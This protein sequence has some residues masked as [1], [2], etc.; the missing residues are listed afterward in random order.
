MNHR[1]K[2]LWMPALACITSSS[3]AMMF[4]QFA[5]IRPQLIWTKPVAFFFY[6]PWLGMLPFCGALGAW[7]SRRAGGG[8]LSR[9]LAVLSPVLWMLALGILVE[10]LELASNGLAH[11]AYFGYGIANWVV[12]PGLA[13]LIGAAPFLRERA[14]EHEAAELEA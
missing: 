5:Q 3:L 9:L 2:S 6:W 4:L 10:P 8:I 7:L 14:G 1:T 12:L 11:L 13:L